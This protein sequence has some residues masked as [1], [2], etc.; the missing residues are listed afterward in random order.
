MYRCSSKYGYSVTLHTLYWY[1]TRMLP[2]AK[3]TIN[4]CHGAMRNR[5]YREFVQ[6]EDSVH[7]RYVITRIFIGKSHREFPSI[8]FCTQYLHMLGKQLPYPIRSLETRTVDCLRY[9]VNNGIEWRYIFRLLV[10]SGVSIPLDLLLIEPICY[11]LHRNTIY[12]LKIDATLCHVGNILYYQPQG[13]EYYSRIRKIFHRIRNKD[14][15][16]YMRI[17]NTFI[18]FVSIFRTQYH[19][20]SYLR[21]SNCIY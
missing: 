11:F 18:D 6:E 10:Q 2:N 21:Y 20:Q 12:Q 13:K 8:Q 3:V 4:I 7:L 16:E 9:A 15:K 14:Y 19:V 1:V 5:V 17:A